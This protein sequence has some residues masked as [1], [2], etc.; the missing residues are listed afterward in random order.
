[1]AGFFGL[2]AAPLAGEA[3][4]AERV[5]RIGLL[6]SQTAESTP[7]RDAF[8]QKLRELGYAEGRNLAIEYRWA[9]GK[10][11]RLPAL[12]GEL[13]R[14][15]VNLIVT[16]DGVAPTLAAKA[17]TKTIPVVFFAGDAVESGLVQSLARPGGNLTGVSGL[18]AGL[19]TKRLR[20]SEGSG[21]HGCSSCHALEPGEPNGCP[22]AQPHGTGG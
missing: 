19:D 4:P 9:E 22:P 5:Y 21:A 8:R 20:D 7:P 3:Q 18:T 14:L 15:K 1:M 12:A 13:A 11:D 17:A 16:P 10:Y 6:S 2:F